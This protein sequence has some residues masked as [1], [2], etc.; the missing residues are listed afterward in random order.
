MEELFRFQQ[1]RQVQ[2]LPE[3]QKSM[4]GLDLYQNSNLSEFAQQLQNPAA[5]NH[6]YDSIMNRYKEENNAFNVITDVKQ[7]HPLIHAI[8]GWIAFKSRPLKARDFQKFVSTLKPDN[9][10][11]LTN[12]WNRYADNLILAI[13]NNNISFNHCIDYQNL[14]RACYFYALCIKIDDDRFEVPDDITSALLNQLLE[15][16]ILLPAGVLRSRCEEDCSQKG[17]IHLPDAGPFQ[18]INREKPCVCPCDNSCQRPSTHCICIRTYIS[19]LFIVKEELAR[20]EEGDIADIENIMAGEMKVRRHRTLLRTENISET[21]K[22]TNTSEERDHQVSEKASLQ[23]EVKNTVDSKVNVDAGVT[24]TLKYGEAVTITPHAN[25][26][27]NFSKSNSENIARSYAKDII[28]RSVSK[29][30]EKVRTLQVSKVLS[31]MEEKNKGSIDN[32]KAGASH[33]AGIFYWV[34]KVTHAQVFNYGKHM[35]FDLIVPEPAAIFKQLYKSKLQSNID[36]NGLHKPT[37]TP[38]SIQRNNY[39]DLLNQY[40]LSSPDESQ[41]PEDTLAIQVAFSQNVTDPDNNKT[42]GFSSHEFKSP[43]IPKGYKAQS[44]TYD[45]RCSTGHPESTGEKDQV[46]VSVHA[47]DICLLTKALSEW[48]VDEAGGN[49]PLPNE[50][51]VAKGTHAMKG[52]EGS[53]TVAV[54]GFSSMALSL[55]GTISVTCKLTDEAF[56]KWQDT[57]YNIIMTDYNRK[58]D[59]YNAANNKAFELVQIKGRNPFLNREIERNEFKRHVISILMCNYFNGMGS[60]MEKVSPCGY[61]EIN[62]DKLEKDAPVIQFFEQVFEWQY[63]N[64]LFYHSMWARKCKWSELIDEDSGD[65]LF[66]KFLTAGASRVQIPVRPGM[67]DLFSWFLKKGQIWGATGEPPISGDD[68]Y[69]SMIRELKE[70][71]NCDYTDRPGFI[72]TTKGSDILKLTNSTFYYDLVHD[73]LNQLN[74]DNDIDRELLVDYKIYRIVGVEQDNPADNT[75]WK[76]TINKPFDDTSTKNLKHAVGALFV[77]APWEIVIPTKLVY[78]RNTADKLPVYPLT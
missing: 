69:V 35:M 9:E 71:K 70:S 49:L 78:L 72:E 55:S 63:M 39:G 46:A 31:E 13:D 18:E 42:M 60:M 4:L 23:S 5:V 12:E 3:E 56:A 33:K 19:D 52:E 7:I 36:N 54:A 30:Q 51:W 29:I 17:A 43:D 41:P 16:S 47:G 65:P 40:G 14:I 10:F 48:A 24:A 11:N 1:L 57:I 44:M 22:E 8:Y 50:N 66:D 25:V 58:L 21:E 27:A 34:N 2:K 75:T 20:F 38:A 77:G 74:I 32:S 45:V 61:P 26:T 67:E 28:D 53:L 62:F 76:I 15:L 37:V 73:Q 59:A 6:T 64:Y 68:E